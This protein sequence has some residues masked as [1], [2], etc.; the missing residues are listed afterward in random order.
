[1]KSSVKRRALMIECTCPVCVAACKS[2]PCWG[3]P[4][5][6]QKL[7]NAGLADQLMEDYWVGDEN[8]MIIAPAICGSEGRHA[9]FSPYGRCTFL[10]NNRCKVHHIKPTEGAESLPCS[11]SVNVQ[12]LH[13]RVA[14]TWD[15]AAGRALVKKWNRRNK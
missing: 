11:D 8:I 6:I 12:E 7:I 15:T 5:D 1:M 13:K 14:M 4:A 10:E 3:T 9:P 2:R